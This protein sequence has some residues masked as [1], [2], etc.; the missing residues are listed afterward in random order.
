MFD[1]DAAQAAIAKLHKQAME[2]KAMQSQETHIKCGSIQVTETS[3]G[4]AAT[5]SLKVS[6]SAFV[7]IE[8]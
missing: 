2:F 6:L 3:N 8:E 5:T 1:L 4:T 7:K